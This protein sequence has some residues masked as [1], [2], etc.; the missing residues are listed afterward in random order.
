MGNV[1]RCYVEKKPGF[2]VE[3]EH[4]F[5]E[6]RHTLGLTGLTGVRVLR[7]YDVEGVDAAVYAAARTTVLSEPQV[8]ALWDEVMPA[9]E[10]EH[11]LLAVE[12]L[13]GQYD[14]RADSCAQCIQMMHGGERPTVRAAT[15]YVLEGALTAPE[16]AKARGYL[17]NPVESREAALDKPATLRQDYPVPAAVPVLDGF[18][19]LDR[20]GLESVLAQYALAMDLADL[21]FL[22]AYFRDEEGRDPTLTEVRVVDTYWSDHCRHTTFS[23][24]LDEVNICNV[25]HMCGDNECRRKCV[26]CRKFRCSDVCKFYKPRECEK[27]NKPPYVCNGCSKKTNCM[28]DKKIYSSKYAQD[29]YETLRTTS[30]EGINQTPESIQKLDILLSPL[31]KKGQSIAHIYASHAD[32]IACSRRTIYSYI[33]RGVFQARNID[34]RRKV[35]Y[36]QRKRKTTTSLKDRS[37]RKGRS[38]KEFLEYIAANKSVYVVEMDTVE[39]AKGTSPCFLTMFFRNCSLMLMFLLEEQTQKEVTRIF[40]HLTELLGIELFQKLFEVILTDN[41]HEFQDRQS[42]E[43]SKNDEVRTRIY[44][45]DPNRSDQKGALEKNHEY[46]RYV[47][48]KGTSFEKMTDKTTLLLLNH[49]NNEKRD[50]LNGHSP[51]EVSRLLLDN[52]LHKALGLAEIPADEVTLIPALIK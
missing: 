33:D 51:Y 20:A 24:H 48:P 25:M 31:L 46:I 44:Y 35:V 7:R 38:Y 41:G 18:T 43:Y 50:S 21:A 1:F 29:S 22:Q 13:P 12:A 32:E 28:M 30:R 16:A 27:L 52:R 3:A 23:T 2:A 8:D 34:L 47:L 49:I 26:L 39:G 42:L 17:I 5:G 11:T 45:C 37:F 40:D 36:K 10:G 6:L 14:Q 4:L 15:V 19:A 9:P